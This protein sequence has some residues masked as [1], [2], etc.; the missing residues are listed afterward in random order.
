M[1]TDTRQLTV[2]DRVDYDI[3]DEHDDRSWDELRAELKRA[4]YHLVNEGGNY[5]VAWLFATDGRRLDEEPPCFDSEQP[6]PLDYA[7]DTDQFGWD[8]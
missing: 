8:D 5:R 7:D 6:S 3:T 2:G 4:D 1:R